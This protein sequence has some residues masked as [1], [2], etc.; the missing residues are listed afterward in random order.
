MDAACQPASQPVG[1]C[2]MDGRSRLFLPGRPVGFIH[3]MRVL[4]DGDNW[5][6]GWDGK[7]KE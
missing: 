4:S 6:F 1:S 5:S 3:G 2:G 7:G